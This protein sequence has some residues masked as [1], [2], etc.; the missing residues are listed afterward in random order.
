ML[1]SSRR[2][3]DAGLQTEDT[4]KILQ[5]EWQPACATNYPRSLSIL[6]PFSNMPATKTQ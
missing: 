1:K 6:P 3:N 2:I 5:I 4:N